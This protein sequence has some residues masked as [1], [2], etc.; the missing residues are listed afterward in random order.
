VVLASLGYVFRHLL[1][2]QSIWHVAGLVSLLLTVATALWPKFSALVRTV[3]LDFVAAVDAVRE[4]RQRIRS[5]CP[6]A[7]PEG[8][9]RELR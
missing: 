3:W 7:R 6:R 4:F 8:G 1:S 2:E 5:G 9:P